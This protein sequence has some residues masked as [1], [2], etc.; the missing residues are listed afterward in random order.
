MQVLHIWHHI[1][2]DFAVF[3]E[4]F[5]NYHLFIDPYKCFTGV[6]QMKGETASFRKG[7]T[8]VCDIK[9]TAVFLHMKGKTVSCLNGSTFLCDVEINKYILDLLKLGSPI[10]VQYC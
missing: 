1:V 9:Q 4:M 10:L 5:L 6:Y 8:F 7:S 2:N 3:Q